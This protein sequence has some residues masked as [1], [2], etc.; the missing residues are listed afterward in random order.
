MSQ[1]QLGYASD[2]KWSSKLGVET[3]ICASLAIPLTRQAPEPV[4]AQDIRTIWGALGLCSR[5]SDAVVT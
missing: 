3:Q 5:V 4:L 2:I 1:V